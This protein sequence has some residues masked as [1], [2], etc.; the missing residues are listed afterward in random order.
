MAFGN[1]RHNGD[2]QY[3]NT[4]SGVLKPVE[5]GSQKAEWGY[6]DAGIV[7]IEGV[8]YFCDAKPTKDGRFMRLKFKRAPERR[9][10]YEKERDNYHRPPQREPGDESMPSD[11]E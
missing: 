4:N 10:G 3:D 5:R 1:K 8:A 7:D 6:T 9:E 11:W 2:K